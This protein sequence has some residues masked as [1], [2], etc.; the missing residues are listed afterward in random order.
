MN[1]TAPVLIGYKT[2]SYRPPIRGVDPIVTFPAT[3]WT[4]AN[5]VF[6]DWLIR[7]PI[8]PAIFG[9]ENCLITSKLVKLKKWAFCQPLWVTWRNYC[10]LVSL[11]TSC[12]IKPSSYDVRMHGSVDFRSSNVRL[13]YLPLVGKIKKMTEIELTLLSTSKNS[14]SGQFFNKFRVCCSEMTNTISIMGFL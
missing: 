5:K 9:R 14:M 1:D 13:D 10:W 7:A 4:R 8:F 3:V 6:C 2:D 12:I 11:K